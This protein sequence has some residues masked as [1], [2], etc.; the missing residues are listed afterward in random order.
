MLIVLTTVNNQ[1]YK[2]FA[3]L[4]KILR[5]ESHAGHSILLKNFLIFNFG[6]DFWAEFWAEFFA[7]FGAVLWAVLW[8]DF[9]ADF[10]ADFWP[11][12]NGHYQLSI[13][14]PPKVQ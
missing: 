12:F 11:I 2:N 6:A 4:P 9:V 8:A 13:E 5:G 7:D 14:V 3:K 10:W 1:S